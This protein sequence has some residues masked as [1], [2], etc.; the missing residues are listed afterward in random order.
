MAV[1]LLKDVL[2][3]TIWETLQIAKEEINKDSSVM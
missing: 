2:I 1:G 3:E